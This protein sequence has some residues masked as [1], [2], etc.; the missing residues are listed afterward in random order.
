MGKY[1]IYSLSIFLILIA[2]YIGYV[3]NDYKKRTDDKNWAQILKYIVSF[4]ITIIISI[5]NYILKFI[6]KVLIW[7]N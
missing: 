2:I 7:N 3:L 1:G 6:M 5:L 4:S